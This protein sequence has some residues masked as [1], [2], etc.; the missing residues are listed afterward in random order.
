[1]LDLL[2]TLYRLVFPRPSVASVTAS[3]NK[4]LKQLQNVQ[5]QADADA[6]ALLDSAAKFAAQARER[7]NEAAAAIRVASKLKALVE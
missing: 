7:Q 5:A 3:I 2:Q 6:D 1:M 4:Q